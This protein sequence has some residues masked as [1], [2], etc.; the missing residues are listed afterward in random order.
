[1]TDNQ[2]TAVL[3]AGVIGASW[4]ALFLASGRSV[5]IY[6]PQSNAEKTV[7]HYVANAWPVLQQLGLTDNGNPDNLSFHTNARD[8][9]N[10][11][12]IHI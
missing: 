9:V 12:L 1:M 2:H 6:D 4:T 8:A 11:S 3:G 10:L 5:A 7:H